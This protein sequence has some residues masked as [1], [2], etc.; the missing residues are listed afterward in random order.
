MN[1]TV[2]SSVFVSAL[3]KD[4]EKHKESLS[5]FRKIKD[6][7]YIAIEPYSVLIEVVAAIRRRTNDM[8]LA[9]RVKSDFLN[10]GSL[11]FVEIGDILAEDA[12]EIAAKIGVRGMDALII[13]TAKEY[14]ASLVSFDNEMTKRA[15]EVVKVADI[16][17]F[18]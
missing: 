5:L 4:E 15:K 7:E 18:I 1:L 9:M 10:I 8:A 12:A 6:A 16:E 3:R 13:Q 2:D 17:K 14:N 11:N